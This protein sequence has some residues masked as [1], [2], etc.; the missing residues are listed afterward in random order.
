MEELKWLEVAVNTTPEQLDEVSAKLTAAGMA[1]LVIEDEAEFLDFLEQ[2]R[3]YW[4]Y[5]DEELLEWK[6]KLQDMLELEERGHR[7]L[8]RAFPKMRSARHH[9]AL[10]RLRRRFDR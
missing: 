3:Q 8:L 4:D 1:S 6:E 10:E 2:N 9:Q 7:R 5:V